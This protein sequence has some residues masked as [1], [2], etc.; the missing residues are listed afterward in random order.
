MS[1]QVIEIKGSDLRV[2]DKIRCMEH[3]VRGGRKE[4]F[5]FIDVAAWHA[6]YGPRVLGPIH[7]DEIYYHSS[8]GISSSHRL[9]IITVERGGH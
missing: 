2:G 7:Q 9:G 5:H 1:T 3:M 4:V 8:E 6:K